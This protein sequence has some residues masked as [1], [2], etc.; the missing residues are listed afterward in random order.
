MLDRASELERLGE[1]VEGF[2]PTLVPHERLP[3]G[4]SRAH[5]LKF[6]CRAPGMLDSLARVEKRTF[7][8]SSQLEDRRA[9]RVQNSDD[10][11]LT[12]VP[13]EFKGMVE[14]SRSFFE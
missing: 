13:S 1:G 11:C 2:A 7:D 8:I 6:V 12:A 10:R 3:Q 14:I 9:V 4:D 5:D